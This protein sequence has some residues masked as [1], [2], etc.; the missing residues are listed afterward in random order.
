[1]FLNMYHKPEKFA[2]LQHSRKIL[3]NVFEFNKNNMN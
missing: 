1:M 3:Y 2:Y